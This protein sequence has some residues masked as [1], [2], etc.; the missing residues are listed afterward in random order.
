LLGRP[1]ERVV[2]G[3]DRMNRQEG[4]KGNQACEHSLL[5]SNTFIRLRILLSF[6]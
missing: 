1:L 2:A 4:G 5:L 3:H 6:K